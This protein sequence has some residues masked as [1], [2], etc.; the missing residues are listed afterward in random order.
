MSARQRRKRGKQ[1]RHASNRSRAKRGALA[2]AGLG[3]GAAL[4]V[5]PTAQAAVDTFTVG[6]TADSSGASDCASATNTDCSLRDAI[7]AADDGDTTDQDH[8]VFKSTLTGSTISLGSNLPYVNE[9]LYVEGLGAANLTVDGNNHKIFV[10]NAP[11]PA[12]LKVAKITL[13][14]AAGLDGPAINAFDGD[15]NG[16]TGGPSLEVDGAILSGNSSSGRGGAISGTGGSVT[17]QDSTI[18]DNA[19]FAAYEGGGGVYARLLTGQN[20]TVENSTVSGNH[21]GGNDAPGGGIRALYTPVTIQDSTVSGNY[22]TDDTAQGGGVYARGTAVTI[23]DSTINGNSSDAP[24]GGIS[25]YSPYGESDLTIEDSTVSGNTTNGDSSFGGGVYAFGSTTAIRGSTI[26]INET[27]G[28]NAGGAGLTVFR[29]EDTAIE[30]STITGNHTDD[31][32]G[33]GG[34]VYSAA[35]PAPGTLSISNST[36]AGNEAGASGYGGGVRSDGDDVAPVLSNTIVADNTAG[37]GGPDLSRGPL[38]PFRAS[39]SMIENP[40]GASIN[41]VVP[42]TNILGVDPELQP[43]ALNDSLN[44]TETLALGST[45]PAVDCGSSAGATTDQ[46]GLTRP[47]DLLGRTNPT[48]PGADGADIGAFELQLPAVASGSCSNNAP[49][50]PPPPVT[51]A[52]PAPVPAA[53][54]TPVPH[55]KKC[56]KKKHK[57]SAQ[58]A[59]KKKC[60]KKKK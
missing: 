29:G 21:T 35:G 42:G 59:K 5:S 60:K 39:F 24:G 40:G 54:P 17:I 43:L 45:S 30:R 37:G 14:G 23:E 34:G 31:D 47:V 44:G 27:N 58:T 56:K 28:S 49:P 22:T 8:I 16:L 2:S 4:A 1:R 57:S 19:A 6:T 13:S 53:S 38:A 41:G 12:E 9:P 3:V 36:I 18:S 55:R 26:A 15:A 25:S 46:R 20:L 51:P 10:I 7:T 48:A 50:P 32:Q 33:F 11:G 52:Q